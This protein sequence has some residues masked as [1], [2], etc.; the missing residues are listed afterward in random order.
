MGDIRERAREILSVVPPL[1]QQINSVG[2]TAS[3]FTQLTGVSQDT[4]T[5]NLAQ[6]GIMTTCNAFTGWFGNQLGSKLYLGRF[7]LD[8]YLP[9]NGKGDAWIKSTPDTRPKYG[10]I[11]RYAKFH[12]GVSLDFEGDIWNHVDSGQGGKSV[13]YDVIKRK[14][15]DT[16]YT[17]AK[18]LGWVD[19]EVYFE[20]VAGSASAQ[21]GNPVP[22]WLLGWWN[23]NWRGQSFYYY[24]GRNHDCQWTLTPPRDTSRPALVANDAGTV[25]VDVP[26][27]LTIRWATTGSVEKF[28]R[29]SNAPMKGTWND[30]EPLTA[31]KI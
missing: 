31:S 17:H 27:A 2:P 1:G 10:D 24:F 30:K 18:L 5:K 4:L 20:G 14:R 12:V 29:Q 21:Q 7:D 15:D 28:A 6:G 13:G 8:T 19:I 3:L 26:N 22:D 25:A 9:K 16:A 11:C 23:V